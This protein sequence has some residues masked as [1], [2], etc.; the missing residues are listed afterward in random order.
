MKVAKKN[1]QQLFVDSL[2]KFGIIV[3]LILAASTK[4]QYSYY[5]FLRWCVTITFSYF[6]FHSYS[7]KQIGQLTFYIGIAILFNP[8]SKF[9]FQKEIWQLIDYT[10]AGF[11][12]FTIIWEWVI[13]YKKTVH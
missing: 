3:A 2:L 4:Q 7:K 13:N 11:I 8:F 1:S 12:T 5:S 6:A 9:W 10:V